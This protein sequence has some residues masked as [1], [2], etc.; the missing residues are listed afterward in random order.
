MR[1][2]LTDTTPNL[3]IKEQEALTVPFALQHAGRVMH[4]NKSAFAR[5][6]KALRDV[7]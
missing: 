1:D 6:F 4:R 5:C 2:F 7:V 3:E